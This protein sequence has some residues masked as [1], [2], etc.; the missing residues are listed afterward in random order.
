MANTH[1]NLNSDE[2]MKHLDVLN[3]CKF[4][5]Y[6]ILNIMFWVRTDLMPE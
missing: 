4:N 2:K 1:A 5:I 3:I 6:Q